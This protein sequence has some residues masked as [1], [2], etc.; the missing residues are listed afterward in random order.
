MKYESSC[1]WE[2]LVTIDLIFWN[3]ESLSIVNKITLPIAAVS[4]NLTKSSNRS[5]S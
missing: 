3:F 5:S 1:H 4:A 2:N